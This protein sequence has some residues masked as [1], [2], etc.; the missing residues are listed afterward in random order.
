MLLGAA[1]RLTIGKLEEIAS[2][3]IENLAASYRRVTAV[4]AMRTASIFGF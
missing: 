1:I 2:F 3:A 4:R